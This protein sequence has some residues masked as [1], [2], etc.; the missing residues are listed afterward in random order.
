[1]STAATAENSS[2][3]EIDKELEAAFDAAMEE[4]ERAGAISE[5]KHGSSVRISSPNSA[6]RS[7]AL[8][9]M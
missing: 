9:A 4:E 5:E 8:R 1:M 2:L 3:F 6:R 7:I